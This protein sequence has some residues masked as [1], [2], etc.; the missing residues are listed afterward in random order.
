M[1]KKITRLKDY[2]IARLKF[3]GAY[4]GEGFDSTDEKEYSY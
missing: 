2:R 4:K 3:G 1:G